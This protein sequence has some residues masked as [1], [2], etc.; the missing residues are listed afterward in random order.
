MEETA[1]RKDPGRALGVAEP[2]EEAV[3]GERGDPLP[4]VGAA[5]QVRLTDSAEASSSWPRP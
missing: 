1:G 2:A 3:G 4:A 5:L